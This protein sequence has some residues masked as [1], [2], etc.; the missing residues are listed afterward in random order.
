MKPKG[1]SA[2]NSSQSTP[3][4]RINLNHLPGFLAVAEHSSFRA[5]AQRMH[6]SQSA[7]S[8]QIRQLEQM[9]GVPLFHRTTRSVNLTSEGQ[10][11]HSVA[12]RVAEEL[13]QVAAAL[14]EDAQLQRG[15]VNVAVLPSLAAT[16]VPGA[17][18]AFASRHPGIDVRLGDADSRRCAD[19]VRQ[20]N[21]HMA[22]MSHGPSFGAKED[23]DFTPLFR[24]DFVAVVPAGHTLSSRRTISLAELARFPLLL[25]PRGVDLREMLQVLFEA[26]KL[27]LQVVQEMTGTHALVALV[28]AGYGVSIQPRMALSGLALPGCN[29]VK[30]R[31]GSGR[32]IGV[33]LPARRSHSPATLAFR[34][35]L[36]EYS[37][38]GVV[39]PSPRQ[40]QT[41]V[42]P[43]PM[44][45][46]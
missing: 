20:G 3:L 17:M 28:A 26:E 38:T 21:V 6:I 23:M 10:R 19:L 45:R 34:D 44:L 1:P 5:A 32:D 16:W 31:G 37:A 41:G 39:D 11:L 14:Q 36:V 42:A 18:R 30:L 35:F 25:N 9:L 29:V 22:L 24:D 12:R 43:A 46:S 2:P 40:G 4:S 8:V 15:V 13:G 33:M 7:L 27:T